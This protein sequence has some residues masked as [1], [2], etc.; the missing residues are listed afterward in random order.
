MS[1]IEGFLDDR[2]AGSLADQFLGEV[3]ALA[4][5]ELHRAAADSRESKLVI[6]DDREFVRR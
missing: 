2:A 5:S 4:R 1:G 3:Q 6:K